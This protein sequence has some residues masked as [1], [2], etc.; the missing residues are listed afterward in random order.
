MPKGDSEELTSDRFEWDESKNRQNKK[1]HGFDFAD[2]EEMFGGIFIAWADVRQDYGEKRWIGMGSIRGRVAIVVFVE[3]D[4]GKIRVVSLRK[5]NSRERKKY[6]KAI[7][8]ELEA[9]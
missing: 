6:E 2:A 7:Q 4:T 3:R 9:G 5:A 1:K 8:D